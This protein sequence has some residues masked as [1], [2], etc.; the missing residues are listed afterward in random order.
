MIEI[1]ACHLDYGENYEFS[2]LGRIKRNSYYKNKYYKS[3]KVT[4]ASYPEKIL[5]GN[6]LS[7]KGYKRVR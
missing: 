4:S 7:Q 6:K 5:V 2:N 1:W 3:G